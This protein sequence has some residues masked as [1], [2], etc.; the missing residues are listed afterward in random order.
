MANAKL[1]AGDL[2]KQP[3]HRGQS[4][5]ARGA[6]KAPSLRLLPEARPVSGESPVSVALGGLMTQRVYN[7]NF[8]EM[9]PSLPDKSVDI[10]IADPPY[11][12]SKGGAWSVESGALPGIGGRWKKI[13]EVWDDMPLNDYLAFTLRWLDEARR[14]LKQTGSMW[15]HGTYHNIGIINV[16]MQTLRIEIINEIVWYKRNSFP[17][18]SGRR[19]TASH[20]TIL[21][22]HRGGRRDYR[23]N[24]EQS[25]FGNYSGD[26]LK[27]PGR[28]MRTVWDIP[29]NKSRE[30][31]AFGAH[32]A[33]KPE[34]LSRRLIQLSA[35][36]GDVCL[37]PFA[38]SGSECVGAHKEGLRFIGFETDEN[39]VE[40][41]RRRLS[42]AGAP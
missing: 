11:N 14:V 24:Y 38:G 3:G 12:A 2:L 7:G 9:A 25:K 30:E 33:Q 35:R 34:R 27:S 41:S 16:A 19:I 17:N 39:Y 4:A 36:P 22:A 1:D 10:I 5:E 20:E 21:W 31:L 6:S 28:Q 18:L 26:R 15:V 40:I 8:M 32:P 42:A 29:N 37:V 13:S 23:F